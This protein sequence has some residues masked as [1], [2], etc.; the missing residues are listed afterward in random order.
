M[1]VEISECRTFQNFLRRIQADHTH[2]KCVAEPDF[3]YRLCAFQKNSFAEQE[4]TEILDSSKMSI[5]VAEIGLGE[6]GK[7]PKIES[8]DRK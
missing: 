2:P 7:R 8:S 6:H 4:F 1:A 3:G 5:S